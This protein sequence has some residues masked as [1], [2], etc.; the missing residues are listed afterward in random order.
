MNDVF[1]VGDEVVWAEDN[2][3]FGVITRIESSENAMWIMKP[4]GLQICANKC[5]YWKKTGRYFAQIAEVLKKM[6][7]E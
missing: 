4:D 6:Q 5:R 2:S 3:E 1:M 7:E